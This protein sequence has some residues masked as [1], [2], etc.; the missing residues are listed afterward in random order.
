MSFPQEWS[1]PD[2]VASVSAGTISSVI[3][4]ELRYALL[5]DIQGNEAHPTQEMSAMAWTDER[6]E[7][8]KK[9]WSEG[10][11]A[12]QIAKQ[13]GGVTGVYTMGVA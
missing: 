7:Q 12:S 4:H 2:L 10:L 1:S 13:L 9:L 8:L 11:S 5:A 3:K 6:V